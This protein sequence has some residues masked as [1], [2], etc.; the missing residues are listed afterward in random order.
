MEIVTLEEMLET[1]GENALAELESQGLASWT[2]GAAGE[3]LTELLG[4]Y[5]LADLEELREEL[6][7]GGKAQVTID[8]SDA[9]INYLNEEIET[10]EEQEAD[11]E[12]EEEEDL[13]EYSEE[14][15]ED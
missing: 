9:I 2:I 5:S 14:D 11:E 6:L 7:E 8:L 12:D 13:E 3:S 10:R 15:K 4:S 1:L